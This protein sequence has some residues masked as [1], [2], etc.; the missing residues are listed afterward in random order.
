MSLAPD[1]R[2]GVPPS[3][4]ALAAM[5]VFLLMRAV[6]LAQDVT[7]PS[8]KAAFIY[9]FAKFTEWPPEAV[10][11][12]A[13]FV[14]CVSGDRAVGDALER[15]VETRLLAGHTLTV[16]QMEPGGPQRGCHVL[17]VSGVTSAQVVQLVTRVRD[18]PVLTISD[19]DG[20]TE[21]GGMVRSSSSRGACASACT[22]M[23]S[24]A[25]VSRSAR[26]CWFWPD[27]MISAAPPQTAGKRATVWL[28]PRHS[29]RALRA[30]QRA[31]PRG[32]S[33][34]H[35]IG[36][37]L[38]LALSASASAQSGLSDLSVEDLMRLDAGQV[39]GASERPQPVIEAPASVSFITAE[40]I[41]RF[42]YRTLADILRGVRGMYVTDDRNFSLIGA[43]GFGKPGDYNSRILLLVNGHRVNDNVFGQAE[44]G[45]E[46]GLDP[47]IFD[48]VE[49]IRGPA[50]SLYGDSAFFAVVNVI[51]KS[52]ASLGGASITVESGT[53]GTQ[54]VR[55]A[56]GHRFGNGVDLALSGTLARSDGVQR[57]YFPVFDAPDSNNGVAEGLDGEG[58][59]QFYGRFAF[60]RLII[61]GT[62]GSRR[63]T[64]PT[65]SF[66]TVFNE[67]AS[68]EQTTD[69]YTLID[70]EYG[71]SFKGTQATF[72][73]AVDRFT[74]DGRYPLPGDQDRAPV[75]GFDS[76]LGLRWT[77][78]VGLTRTLRGRQTIR[79]GVERIGN[80]N[81]DQ[82]TS[83]SGSPDDAV[84]NHRS[85]AQHALYLQDEIKMSGWFIV[86]AGL[87]YDGY[88]E[89]VKVTPRAALIYLP[90]PAQSVKYL[91]GSAFR[92]PNTYELNTANFG[93]RVRY[94][95]PESIDTH[96]L[97]WEGYINDWLRT[98]VSTY[99]YKADR[100]I[101]AIQ[102]DE[103]FLG[104]SFI[105][106]G[107][108]RARGLELEAQMRLKGSTRALV[109]Y[110]LQSA[111]DQ[112][113]RDDLPNSPRHLVNARL[114]LSGPFRQSSIAVEGRYLS[115]RQT[116][117]GATVSG[118]ATANITMIQPVGRA[119][120]LFGSVQ[121]IFDA[122]FQDPS[123]SAHRQDVIPQ[124]GRTARLGLRWGYRLPGHAGGQ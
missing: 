25:A 101:T 124:N 118:T 58:I 68:P 43:R 7:E 90:S 92:A 17:Y 102:D 120:Q 31:W 19:L 63:R 42:G 16:V 116:L 75:V 77:L 36:L 13:P 21:P 83:L 4:V 27:H 104:I 60:K 14:M 55:A 106:Q 73:A 71:R 117:A 70:A 107:E 98:S 59:G 91:F 30:G 113:T 29:C 48:R 11:A 64:V 86:N 89:F 61:T 35:V 100:L 2:L 69:R 3:R 41:A 10:A 67:Q 82:A 37:L 88:E 110:A 65:A 109:S 103:S 105:N 39:F 54:L 20:F 5:T 46:F 50:S 76:V 96:E 53:L 15:A 34:R 26:G 84:T 81:Q 18:V 114:S 38:M 6:A 121:N 8:L 123:S 74:Y 9:N 97:V 79:A 12:A 44:I 112:E 80:L 119:W 57:L 111:V 24:S 87:R 94:L 108:V 78:G 49:V 22:S 52:G 56:L 122:R 85:S 115:S 28:G 32:S 45:A 47:A 95:R 99:W 40:E 93:E 66:G 62:Y 1:T 23:P 33:L 72:R 51:T